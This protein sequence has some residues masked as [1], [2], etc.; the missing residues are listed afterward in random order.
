MDRATFKLIM[1]IGGLLNS[2]LYLAGG[3]FAGIVFGDPHV[4]K[5]ALFAV[6]LTYLSYVAQF[7]ADANSDSRVLLAAAGLAPVLVW[8]SIAIGLLAGLVLL[9]G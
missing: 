3:F 6:G 2:A 1:A 8:A 9:F 4:V 5:L 7:V